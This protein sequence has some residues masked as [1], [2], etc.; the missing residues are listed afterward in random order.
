MAPTGTIGGE[1]AD[2]SGQTLNIMAQSNRVRLQYILGR[3][4]AHVRSLQ[5]EMTCQL[6][7]G[8]MMVN[9]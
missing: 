8:D 9:Q 7:E 4:L 6:C 1:R 2:M 5:L 3:L